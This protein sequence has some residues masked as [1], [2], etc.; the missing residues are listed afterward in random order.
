MNY[1]NLHTD[2]LRSE[3]YLGCDPTERATWLNLMAW[4]ASQENGGVIKNCAGWA[5]RK[6]LQM[7][8]I[9]KKEV[10]LSCSLYSFNDT[11][12]LTVAFYPS[13][14]ESEVVAKREIAKINGA[15]G[16]RPKKEKT[17]EPLPVAE[18]NRRRLLAGT[19]VGFSIETQTEPALESVR[20]GKGKECNEN[21]KPSVDEFIKY[22]TKKLPT[23]NPEWTEER[24]IR[25]SKSRHETYVSDGWKDGHGKTIKNW[26]T[27]AVNA[28]KHEK[29][30]SYGNA[31]VKD[32]TNRFTTQL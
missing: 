16:G 12:D 3:D 19:S 30:W 25:A 8:G 13:D 17:I 28:I 18:E 1:L 29:P 22:L 11:F 5:D 2:T 7:C 10:M 15:K 9:T 23:I 14:K 26:K 32:Q 21:T 20:E 4:C 6:W 27:K 31:E 24:A